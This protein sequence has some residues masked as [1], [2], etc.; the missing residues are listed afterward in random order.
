MIHSVG[1]RE[2]RQVKKITIINIP[3]H[4]LYQRQLSVH[5]YKE[6]SSSGEAARHETDQLP[7]S[8]VEVKNWNGAIGL[9]ALPNVP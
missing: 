2:Q 5:T 7:P 3:C 8:S 4:S 1:T 9:P 6:V